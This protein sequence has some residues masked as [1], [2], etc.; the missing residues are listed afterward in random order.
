M[1]DLAYIS[2]LWSIERSCKMRVTRM[3]DFDTFKSILAQ[4][5]ALV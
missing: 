5:L 1:D 2:A 3:D 4:L